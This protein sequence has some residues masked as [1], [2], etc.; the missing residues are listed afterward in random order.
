MCTDGLRRSADDL[1]TAHRASLHYLGYLYIHEVDELIQ[2]HAQQLK[3]IGKEWIRLISNKEHQLN[4]FACLVWV[5]M[6]AMIENGKDDPD[7]ILDQDA[8]NKIANYALS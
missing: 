1:R 6:M 8:R 7:E 5:S 3:M 2:K 4:Y